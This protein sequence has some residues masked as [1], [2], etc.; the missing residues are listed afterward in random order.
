MRRSQRYRDFVKRLYELRRCFLP[1]EFDPLGNYD[2]DV[3][4]KASAYI[5]LAHA[6]IESFIEDRAKETAL[7]AIKSWK[8]HKKANCALIGL[9]GYYAKIDNNK[10]D[11]TDQKNQHKM[12][13][14]D[15]ID[16]SMGA[17]SREI[18]VNHG[19]RENNIYK[20]LTPIG[21]EMDSFDPTWIVNMENYGVGRGEIAHKSPNK[22]TTKKQINPEE[23][24]NMVNS[25]VGD[26]LK[27]LDFIAEGLIKSL[28]VEDFAFILS[29]F[30]FS[31]PEYE[32]QAAMSNMFPSLAAEK[33][34]N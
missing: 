25:L 28:C 30:Q 31:E 15:I 11:E 3:L 12:N 32:I 23:E 10:Q 8:E 5:V 7:A 18:E 4:M 19:I 24:F 22:Y 34:Q 2:D 21:I 29:H 33:T 17:F 26:G 20:L 1:E 13:I 27:K 16:Q 14:I 6:E 9:I